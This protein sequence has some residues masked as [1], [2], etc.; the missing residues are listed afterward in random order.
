MKRSRAPAP[1][2]KVLIRR[3]RR[4]DVGRIHKL[5][6]EATRSGKIL[7]RS[8]GEISR[9]INRFRVAEE[10]GVV[11]ACCA[12]EVYGRKLAEVRSLAVH[13]ER[14]GRG[15]ASALVAGCLKE[16]R[17]R[18]LYEVLAITDRENIFKRLGF[19]EQLHGQKALFVR[20]S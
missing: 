14:R 19:A 13:P 8:R 12:L 20:P 15:I 11:V 9:L 1:G 3:A 2:G 18:R 6:E 10:R 5:I 4:A 7:K 16:A 17:R